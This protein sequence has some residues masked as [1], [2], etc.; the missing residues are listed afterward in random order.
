M[1]PPPPYAERAPAG[2]DAPFTDYPRRRLTLV[3]LTLV[4]AVHYVDRQIL[5]VLIPS[6]KAEYAVSDTTLGLLSGFAFTVL[7]SVSS[8][9]VARV[10]DRV[11]RARVITWSLATFT[12]A[13]ALCGLVA[14]FW[15]LVAMRV[16]VGVGEGGTNPASHALVADMYPARRRAA[17]MATYS[18]GPYLG[19]IVAFGG[20]AALAQAFGWRTAYLVVGVLGLALVAATAALLRDPRTASA[21]PRSAAALPAAAAARALWA[22]PALRHILIAGTL[23]TAAGQALATWLPTWLT[24]EH[25]MELGRAG[26]FLGVVLGLGGA[27]ATFAFGRLL[28]RMAAHAP[29]R[30]P[31][32]TA[33]CMAAVAVLLLPALLTTDTTL[34]V[35]ALVLPASGAGAYIGATF[36]MV[37]DRVDPRARAFSAAVMLTVSNL[38]GAGAGPLV[39]GIASDALAGSAHALS[40]AL[41]AAPVLLLWSAWHYARAARVPVTPAV[42]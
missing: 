3:L 4:F 34:A 21:L 17:A 14:A 25:G 19:V 13:T 11:D 33:A 12:V 8:L 31:L 40:D 22:S 36:A 20:G 24:R 30:K 15:Q 35:A 18:I 28:D 29:E 10:A 32:F 16:I 1:T 38:V 23:A 27:G 2:S 5:A 7:F 37:Q 26:A 42:G 9:L 6:I 41:L 39:V